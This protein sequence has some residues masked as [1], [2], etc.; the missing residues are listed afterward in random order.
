MAP[1]LQQFAHTLLRVAGA[2]LAQH[3]RRVPQR[4]RAV[5]AMVLGGFAL[6]VADAVDGNRGTTELLRGA[7]L[8]LRELG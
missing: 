3:L 8:A 1:H 2:A 4:D 6:A 7:S 5:S